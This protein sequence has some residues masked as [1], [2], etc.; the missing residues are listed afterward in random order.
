MDSLSA[1]ILAAGEGKRMKSAKTKVMHE[2]LYKPMICWA[3]DAARNAGIPDLCIVAGKNKDELAAVLREAEVVIQEE[4]LGTAHALMQAKDFIAARGGDV[5]VFYGDTP[6]VS[7]ETLEE[8]V[9]THRESGADMTVM[10]V[11]TE[12][13]AGYGRM[14]L[15][16]NGDLL[17]IVE[18]R[19]ATAAER[20]VK[21]INGGF[22]CFKASSLLEI[23]PMFDNDNAQNEYY[24]TD[25]VAHIRAKGGKVTALLCENE[26]EILG[27]NDRVQL[28][29][30]AGILRDRVNEK[31]MREGVTIIDPASAYISPDALIGADTVIEPNVIVKGKSQIGTNCHIGPNASIE[32][33]RI[34][35]GSSVNASQL[36]WSIIGKDANIGPFAYIR[37]GCMLADNVKIGDFVELKKAEIGEGTKLPHLTYAG[38]TIIGSHVN[39]GCGSVTVNYDGFEKHITEIGDDAFIGCNT[40]LVA[41]VKIGKGVYTAAGSTITEDVPDDALS[42]ARARQE[43]KPGW[44]ARYRALHKK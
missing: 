5:L 37:P 12:N 27:V 41:P 23:F 31:L 40:N 14:I 17:K 22:Y 15:D 19:D 6:L 9:E 2:I 1:V 7:S 20:A 33:C 43:N 30:A 4:Q 3:M 44:A 35:D 13:P 25:A 10:G 38:D 26:R 42:V 36:N 39:V 34:G 16:E 29:R 24:L 11:E 32:E 28:A 8:L 18:D 21:S